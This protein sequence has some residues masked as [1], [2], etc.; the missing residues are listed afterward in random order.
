MFAFFDDV[1]MFLP[2]VVPEIKW[3]G[4]PAKCRQILA[5]IAC[6]CDT[7]EAPTYPIDINTADKYKLAQTYEYPSYQEFLCL[8]SNNNQEI[9]DL[10]GIP[11]HV[12]KCRVV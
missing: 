2:A 1:L 9:T 3:G 10:S 11:R 4:E 7:E 6:R 5:D 8:S 12:V